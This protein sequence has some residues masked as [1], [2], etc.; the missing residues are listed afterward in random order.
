MVMSGGRDGCPVSTAGDA[1][2]TEG[3]GRESSSLVV[4]GGGGSCPVS[5]AGR[6]FV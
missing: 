2:G 3:V 1:G 6:Q 4:S 5:T